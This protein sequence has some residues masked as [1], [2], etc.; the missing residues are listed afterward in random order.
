MKFPFIPLRPIIAEVMIDV[1]KI[2]TKSNKDEEDLYI[3]AADIMRLI[4]GNHYQS[5]TAYLTIN[6]H[7]TSIP[8][9]F[10]LIL[11]VWACAEVEELPN[12]PYTPKI[13]PNGYN[14]IRT[15]RLKPA[16]T[17]TIR[18]YTSER[19]NHTYPFN[20]TFILKTPP[21]SLR[22]SFSSGLIEMDY[23]SLPMSE[24]GELLIQDEINAIMAVKNYLMLS[25][26]RE[27]YMMGT[28]RGDVW[29]NFQKEYE[30]FLMLAQQT[31]RFPDHTETREMK[32]NIETKYS[33]FRL[34]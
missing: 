26:L 31:Q 14:T 30:D 13:K 22:T 28:V 25:L 5:E 27:D 15:G 6:K 3:W 29:Q 32:E 7:V 24:D 16:D 23:L 4:G 34:R 2:I 19:R 18:L 1:S 21:G 9:N 8:K 10:Y 33:R 17:N 12:T 20:H 11:D